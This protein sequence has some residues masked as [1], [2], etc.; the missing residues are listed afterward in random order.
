M[1]ISSEGGTDFPI[2]MAVSVITMIIPLILFKFSKGM[3]FLHEF[4]QLFVKASGENLEV[5]N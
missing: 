3:L 2:A 4:I 5:L 1:F